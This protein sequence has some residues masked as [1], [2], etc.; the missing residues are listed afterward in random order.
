MK[1]L[2]RSL[3]IFAVAGGILTPMNSSSEPI[4]P[5]AAVPSAN[6]STTST[7]VV[8][9]QNQTQTMTVQPLLNGQ[10]VRPSTFQYHR[11]PNSNLGKTIDPPLPIIKQPSGSEIRQETLSQLGDLQLTPEQMNIIKNIQ[12]QRDRANAMPYTTAAKP[13]TRTLSINLNPGIQP[14]VIRL[15]MGMQTSIV[16]SDGAG[17]PWFIDNVVLNR[18]LFNDQRQETNSNKDQT[19]YKGTNI[20]TLEPMTS[21][22]YGNVSITLKGMTTPI[23]LILTSG[24]KEVDVRVDTKVPGHNPDSFIAQSYRTMP[25]SDENLGYFLDGIPPSGSKALKVRGFPGTEAWLYQN[26]TY[27]KT[28]A[29]VQ[30]PAFI[31]AA[32]ATTGMGIYKFNGKLSSVTVLSGG[33]AITTFLE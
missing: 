22:P 4:L 19:N 25:S 13:V 16:F 11:P 27:V 17:N 14:P 33:R 26:N 12:L 18:S 23:I 31:S 3:L 10:I 8:P 21:T 28:T 30:F 24:G 7:I 20:L 2:N 29:E 1:L 6:N 15:A 9:A 32:K 5:P